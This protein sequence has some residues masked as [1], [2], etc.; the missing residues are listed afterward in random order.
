MQ[1]RLVYKQYG[2]KAGFSTARQ[3]RQTPVRK[4]RKKPAGRWSAKYLHGK[5]TGQPCYRFLNSVVIAQ[6]GKLF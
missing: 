3:E 5:T 2:I 1:V 4:E 6:A